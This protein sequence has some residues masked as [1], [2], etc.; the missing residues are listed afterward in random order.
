M[1]STVNL[2]KG[3]L[4]T[5]GFIGF[6]WTTCFFGFFVPFFRGDWRGLVILFIADLCT[7]GIAN[8]V[9]CFIYNK[10]YTRNLIENKGYSP[11]DEYSRQ[12]LIQAGIIAA[13]TP[14]PN[15]NTSQ[16]ANYENSEYHAPTRPANIQVQNIQ[17]A[18]SDVPQQAQIPQATPPITS[19]NM[20]ESVATNAYSPS[21]NDEN[22]ESHV[23]MTPNTQVQ[24]IH[25]TSS[26]ALQQV[27]IPPQTIP[28]I[29]P[30]DMRETVADIHPQH[31]RR[32]RVFSSSDT[33]RR[34][35]V[36]LIA[37][38]VVIAII[39]TS[40]VV[41]YINHSNTSSAER[42]NES[43]ENSQMVD[44]RPSYIDVE[45][46]DRET[47]SAFSGSVPVIHGRIRT[48]QLNGSVNVRN[49]P[50]IHSDVLG[51]VKNGTPLIIHQVQRNAAV[52]EGILQKNVTATL[53]SGKKITLDKNSAV[54]VVGY[55]QNRN[56]VLI[57][58]SQNNV[59][60]DAIVGLGDVNFLQNSLWYLV[61]FSDGSNGWV[62]SDL[63]EIVQ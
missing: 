23:T 5:K 18:L 44:M 63:V 4:V 16:S 58:F 31:E 32:A 39:I 8:I 40:G 2:R 19:M 22:S 34:N 1:A 60:A 30:V 27:R 51:L 62:V 24:D 35:V 9:F 36:P 45:E 53:G 43:P 54:S 33:P 56:A 14:P 61:E 3:D 25:P 46:A 12:L 17:P 21:A 10:M 37:S 55:D 11:A 15:E 26:E 13:N 6:S 59:T 29:A 7:A 49:A 52:T 38:V 57:R 41:W 50:S 42:R 28:P 48:E 20:H 47:S